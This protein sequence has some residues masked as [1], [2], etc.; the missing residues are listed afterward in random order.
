MP[1]YRLIGW[2]ECQD[3][4]GNDEV[5]D[6]ETDDG[7]ACFVQDKDGDHVLLDWPEAQRYQYLPGTYEIYSEDDDYLGTMVPENMLID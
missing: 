4:F 5:F 3:D 7:P 2:P 6:V 1:K